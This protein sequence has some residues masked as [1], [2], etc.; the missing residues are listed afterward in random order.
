MDKIII[1][2]LRTEAIIG[3]YPDER[4]QKQTLT[5]DVELYIDTTAKGKRDEL[6]NTVDYAAVCHTIQ[7]FINQTQ[8]QLIETLAE[9][10]AE[11]LLN[12]FNIHHCHLTIHKKP[13][14]IPDIKSV[15]VQIERHANYFNNLPQSTLITSP[16]MD[17]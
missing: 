13:F 9:H 3:V 10:I 17:D 12:K 6:S 8:F 15:A 2:Q 1:Q 4:Q 14:D 7:T 16:V 11:Q 5:I